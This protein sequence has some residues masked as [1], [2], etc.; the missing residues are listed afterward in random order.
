MVPKSYVVAHLDYKKEVVQAGP[1]RIPRT[2]KRDAEDEVS[3]TITLKT[4]CESWMGNLIQ[5]S[6]VSEDEYIDFIAFESP[7]CIC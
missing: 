7:C 2:Q 6:Q 4:C 3:K 5:R 1:S